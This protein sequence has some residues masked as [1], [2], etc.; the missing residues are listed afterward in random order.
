LRTWHA[1]GP[2]FGHAS[3][4]PATLNPPSP[5]ASSTLAHAP[6]LQSHEDEDAMDW[7]PT[8]SPVG[9]ELASRGPLPARKVPNATTGLETLLERTNIIDSSEPG[10]KSS[11]AKRGGRLGKSPPTWSW[12]WVY[13]LSLVP[14]VGVM[15]YHLRNTLA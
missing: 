15:Y 7:T 14:L 1:T 12:G 8:T 3:L 11:R 4:R 2:V 5:P 9:P 6:A 13:A 10:N